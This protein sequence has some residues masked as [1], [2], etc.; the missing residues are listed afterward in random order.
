MFRRKEKISSI[1]IDVLV[2]LMVETRRADKPFSPDTPE[3]RKLKDAAVDYYI[4]DLISR[5]DAWLDRQP[6]SW[7]EKYTYLRWNWL[8]PAPSTVPNFNPDF[9]AGPWMFFWTILMYLVA[10]F[11]VII[12]CLLAYWVVL[13][14]FAPRKFAAMWDERDADKAKC[15][16]P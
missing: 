4:K 3:E 2:G 14:F 9:K 11:T 1:P 8:P 7:R 10:Y 13:A 6:Q 12:W 15:A 5:A 16:S